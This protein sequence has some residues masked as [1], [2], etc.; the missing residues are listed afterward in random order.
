MPEDISQLWDAHMLPH[1]PGPVIE[2]NI[3]GT[4]E[5]FHK[6]IKVHHSHCDMRHNPYGYKPIQ[7]DGKIEACSFW[8][9]KTSI[10]DFSG[11][12]L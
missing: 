2:K 12:C 6:G 11:D 4:C 9:A 7:H 3:C 1:S 8:K 10:I 5:S